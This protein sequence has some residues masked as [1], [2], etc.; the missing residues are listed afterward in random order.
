MTD[1]FDEFRPAIADFGDE[2]DG[3][4]HYNLGVA[5]WEMGLEA[6]AVR[7]LRAATMDPETASVAGEA[8][9]DLHAACRR[10]TAAAE[11]Y[12]QLLAKT[13]VGSADENRLRFRLA[14]LPPGEDGPEAT[15]SVRASRS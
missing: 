7:E 15:S 11:L 4:T 5:Y 3:E 14:E 1:S 2:V 6:D 12:R 10:Y 13:E 8:L 9:A